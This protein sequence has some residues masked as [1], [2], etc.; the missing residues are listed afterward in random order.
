MKA[1]TKVV[2]LQTQDR[3]RYTRG[4]GEVSITVPLGEKITNERAV[5]LLNHALA[6][7]LERTS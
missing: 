5:F 2:P 3:W 4:D 7:L 6:L 1:E